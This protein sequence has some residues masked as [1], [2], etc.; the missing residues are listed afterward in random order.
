MA[1]N[2]V[3]TSDVNQVAVLSRLE[4]NEE[5]TEGLKK[6]LGE[7]VA[8]FGRLLEVDTTSVSGED[9]ICGELRPDEVGTNLSPA[10]VV[11]NAPHHNQNAFIV[12]RVVE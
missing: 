5:E 11:K 3:K 9:R 12:P 7:I 6:D 4:F 10:D 2:V 8:Y 1:K